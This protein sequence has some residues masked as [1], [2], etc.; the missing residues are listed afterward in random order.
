MPAGGH[1]DFNEAELAR[2]LTFPDGPVARLMMRVGELGTQEAKR[3]C[4]TSPAGSGGRPSG[5][6][7]S[8]IGWKLD[9][10]QRGLHVDIRSTA[11][12]PQGHNYGLDVELGTKPHV[13]ESHG[14]YP[15][16]NA[17]TRQVFGR[18]VHHPGT[19]A[20]PFLRPC[21]EVLRGQL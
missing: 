1:I 6:L 8:R 9:R 13:I 11:L 17:R 7:R 21:V 19:H 14:P 16:R 12:T 10:D 20:Q 4:P 5:Y 2:L 18:T 15:L 3:L